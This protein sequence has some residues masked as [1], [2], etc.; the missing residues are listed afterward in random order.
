MSDL[1]DLAA[2]G[3]TAAV[4]RAPRRR[5][6]HRQRGNGGQTPPWPHLR[7]KVEMA[8][9]YVRARRESRHPDDNLNIPFLL[10]ARKDYIDILKLRERGGADPAT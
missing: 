4:A 6:E 8:S 5:A 7:D 10:L 1:V 9:L 2:R 3:D